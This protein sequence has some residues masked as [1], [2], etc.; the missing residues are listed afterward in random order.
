MLDRDGSN[1]YSSTV[2][3]SAGS[4]ATTPQLYPTYPNPFNPQ[5]TVHFMLPSDQMVTV[6]L[7]DADGKEA[8]RLY[9]NEML[10]GGY[11]TR[12]LNGA[13]LASGKYILRMTAGTYHSSE[14]LII[15]K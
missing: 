10:K 13:R 14:N 8:L 7:Y 11:Y 2:K 9:D 6:I 3:I 15:E 1:K 5:A 12:T 4:L